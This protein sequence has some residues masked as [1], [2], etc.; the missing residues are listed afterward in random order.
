M[1]D[2]QGADPGIRYLRRVHP[3][4]DR[5]DLTNT[6]EWRAPRVGRVLR[7]RGGATARVRSRL[8][9]DA[10]PLVGRRRRARVCPRTRR[11]RQGSTPVRSAASGAWTASRVDARPSTQRDRRRAGA[12]ERF[13]R[14][15][16][17]WSLAS[18]PPMSPPFGVDACERR[19]R[20]RHASGGE[21]QR[22]TRGEDDQI[23]RI[24]S[25]ARAD[26]QRVNGGP[27][28]P[29]WVTWR[30]RGHSRRR[31]SRSCR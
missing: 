3:S 5:R 9:R 17:A 30:L 31:C 29:G 10:A 21:R 25:E 22:R 26:D 2:R 20:R 27:S 19:L 24:A 16:R 15:G 12:R 23:R 4:P 8:V 7:R 18:A 1:Q 28:W 13:G 11:T 14:A 6:R